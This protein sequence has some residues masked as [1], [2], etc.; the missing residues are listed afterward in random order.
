MQAG[1]RRIG[2]TLARGI[3]LYTPL[4]AL[5][6]TLFL[7][8]A[9]RSV[10]VGGLHAAFYT[11]THTIIEH[12]ESLGGEGPIIEG[13]L[14]ELRPGDV[15]W[16]IGASFGL[17]TVLAAQK[18]MPQG[19][20]AAFEPEP[21][22]RGLL[23]RNLTLNGLG[24]VSVLSTALGDRD[25]V[26]ELFPAANPNSGTSSLARREDYRLRKKGI[27]VEL[28]RGETL[29]GNAGP[30]APTCLKIDVEGGEGRVLAG[31]GTL[32]D[33]R[34]LRFILCE[35]HPRLLPS[36]GDNAESFER[37]L[38]AAGFTITK[39]IPRGSEYHLVC[40]R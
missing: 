7:S 33:D 1:F 3:G 4:R 28:R 11:P 35:V 40:R 32:L 23:M 20:V 6:N 39:K 14:G 38:T 21:Q 10:S 18:V 15:F 29:I 22:M 2:N 31:M 13:F 30:P 17:Y 9:T 16:D 34:R 27:S 26:T 36:F 12:V 37:A 25:A 8:R 5:Y 19:A 24:S